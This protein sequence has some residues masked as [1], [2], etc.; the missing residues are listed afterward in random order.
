MEDSPVS[1]NID[2][3]ETLKQGI[4][5]HQAGDLSAAKEAYDR[6]LKAAPGHA[7]AL[8]L[9]GLIAHQQ[10]DNEVATALISK[11]ISMDGNVALY[12]ANLG[13]VLKASGND[14]AAIDAF[15]LA[16]QIEPE[17][18]ALHADL[19]S[20]FLGAGEADA[21]R[22]RAN[23][24]LELDPGS[25][26]A[27]VNL[28]LALQELYGPAHSDAVSAFRRAISLSPHIPGAFLGLGVALHEAGD[29]V[30]AKQAYTQAIS[31]NPGFIEAHCNLGNLA[32]DE[33]DFATAVLHYR[34]ALELEPAQS[35]VWGNLAVALQESGQLDAAL[36]AYDKA[37]GIEPDNPEIRRNRG[38][39]LLAK[40]HFVEGWRDYEFR[41]QTKRFRSIR[42]EWPVHEWDGGDLT[43]KRILVHAEQGLGDTLMFCRYLPML[44]KLGAQVVFECAD[45]LH[46]IIATLQKD[47]K[48]ITPGTAVSN[49]DCHA[50]LLSLPG[51][52][53]TTVE[54]I[55]ADVPYLH[56]PAWRMEKW[57]RIVKSW[58]KG[59]KIGIAWRGSPDHARDEIRSPGLQPFMKLTE[60]A[61]VTLVSL[62][63]QGGAEELATIEGA[64]KIIDPT[65]QIHDFADTAV[66][67]ANLDA[68][69]SC[70]SAPLHLAG[71]L[72]I[73]TSA[74]LPHVSEWRWGQGGETT[75]WYPEMA[76][77][78]QRTP[79]NW[80]SVFS[81]ITAELK[82]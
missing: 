77:V 3:S 64:G 15:K 58:P 9:S 59:L 80:A 42:R 11:A 60:D 25:A 34:S 7:D 40:G 44:Q 28:G 65:S 17:T 45:I 6:I 74:V 30:G 76:L 48:I 52:M 71:A 29:R 16:I 69:V 78:R 68:V 51:L 72:G 50:A 63:K 21:A 62:Q 27:N 70:D 73:P 54:S 18:A 47:L 57:Q 5:R 49:V 82:R 13:R 2:L 43:G 39:A 20:A 46:P 75:P 1:M 53:G 10:G 24:A 41:W 31:L 33:L 37:I 8:H 56:A 19:A 14:V 36:Q 35:V 81:E 4:A 22:S 66:L 61:G 23:L 79:G 26:E 55:P 38:M 12:H 67:M 32:R